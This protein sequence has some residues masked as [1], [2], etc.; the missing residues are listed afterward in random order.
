MS[1][2][3]DATLNAKGSLDIGGTYL[4]YGQILDIETGTINFSGPIENAGLNILATR[5]TSPVKAGVQITGNLRIPTVKLV[6]TPDVSDSDKLSWLIL[7]QPLDNAGESGLAVLSLAAST[8]LSNGNSVPL[9]TRLARSA[10]LDS[11][12]VSGSGASTYSVSVGKRI[13][14][15]LYLGY[16]KSLFGL[17]NIAKLTYNITKRISLVTRAGSDSA[18]DLLYTFSFD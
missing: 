14:P 17:L 18:V 11:L 10:G 15:K 2:K 13:T 9:Q 16:E 6:S 5:N 1:G 12:N 3:P 4:A 8:I 7:G